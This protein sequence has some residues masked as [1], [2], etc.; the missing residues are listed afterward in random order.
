MTD[1]L[2]QV[3]AEY[4]EALGAG[5]LNRIR[6]VIHPELHFRTPLLEVWGREPF[7]FA[8]EQVIART[9]GL[10]LKAKF[11][12]GNQ[13]MFTYDLLFVEPIGPVRTANLM[14]FEDDKIRD[15]ELFYDARPFQPPAT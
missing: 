5:D 1:R 13:A 3:G 10:V 9:H 14:T 4:L 6:A 11:A 2:L 7:I 12:A 8:C 15:V